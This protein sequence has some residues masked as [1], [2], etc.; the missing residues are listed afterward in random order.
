MVN[1]SSGKSDV[2]RITFYD[3]KIGATAIQHSNGEIEI[4]YEKKNVT[5]QQ[6]AIVLAIFLGASLFKAFGIMPFIDNETP[7]VYLYL[8]PAIFYLFL[9]V[10]AIKSV[11][12]KGNENL[13]RNHGAEHMVF[14]AYKKLKRVPSIEEAK[15]FSRINR[16]CGVTIFSAFFTA[17]LIG[18]FVY[19]YTNNQISEWIL[20]LVP[21]LFG[22]IFPFNTLGKLAQFWTTSKPNDTNINL[23]ITAMSALERRYLLK[24]LTDLFVNEL[25]KRF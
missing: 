9:T 2:D 20:F 13:L 24:N 11:R 7:M 6:V 5:V 8:L 23:A 3:S 1:V 22:N 15:R 12:K 14:S 19:K 21:L 4:K 18:F 10:T 25:F 16:N 17:Q